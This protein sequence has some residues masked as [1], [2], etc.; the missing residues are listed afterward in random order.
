MVNRRKFHWYR[1]NGHGELYSKQLTDAWAKVIG[2]IL[3]FLTNHQTA[4]FNYA[5]YLK[6]GPANWDF[7][8]I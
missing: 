2:K 8:N 7:I 4:A 5:I 1:E 3:T 6:K